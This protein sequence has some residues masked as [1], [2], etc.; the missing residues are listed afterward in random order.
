M[1]RFKKLAMLMSF[2]AVLGLVG[3]V[4]DS[5]ENSSWNESE[6]ESNSNTEEYLRKLNADLS[7]FLKMPIV[8][9]SNH[10]RAFGED[11]SRGPDSLQ[12]VFIDFPELPKDDLDLDSVLTPQDMVDLMQ[13]YGAE[14]SLEDDGMRDDSIRI[15]I[16]AAET[17][18]TPLAIDS[19]NFLRHRGLSDQDMDEIIEEMESDNS[20]L[21]TLAMIIS[22]QQQEQQ[23]EI[24]SRN[25]KRFLNILSL[26]A[27]AESAGSMSWNCI[28]KAVGIND[29][30]VLLNN[31]AGE[32]LTKAM[33]LCIL[34]KGLPRL[35][36]WVGVAVAL[37]EFSD[38]M[39]HYNRYF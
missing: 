24:I 21:I 8:S 16:E 25:N 29:L 3:L 9:I 2:A 4:I 5:C 19:R 33:A 15:S 18:L 27:Y 32:N 35:F 31:V 26:P 36:G 34:K 14:F 17:A 1:S 7:S 13:T 11:G 10:S 37:V 39:V 38:C 30:R 28:K 22:G 12:T 6:S 23:A 20:C